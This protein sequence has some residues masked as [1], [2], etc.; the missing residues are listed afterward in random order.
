[1]LSAKLKEMDINVAFSIQH[2]DDV[3]EFVEL[4]DSLIDK[5]DMLITTGAVSVG[6]MDIMH[7]VMERLGAKRLFWK[8]NMRPGTPVMASIY[9]GKLILGLSGNPLAAVTT[10]ELLFRPMLC[11]FL[12]T[13]VYAIKHTK[14]TLM[15]DFNK[16][17]HQRRFVSARFLDNQVYLGAGDTSSVLSGML[18]CNCFID[19]KAG[20][21]KIKKGDEVDIVLI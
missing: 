15:N 9:R 3:S 11:T 13:D 10:F 7:D 17:S 16:E 6:K 2:R 12:H 4:I 14:A 5:V 8:V 1:V 21:S 20:T 19:V 18:D